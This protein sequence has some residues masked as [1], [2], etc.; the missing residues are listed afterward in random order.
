MNEEGIDVLLS[1]QS[2]PK[3]KIGFQIK[4]KTDYGRI[5]K[6]SPK[7]I[8]SFTSKVINQIVTSHKH[9]LFKS[10]VVFAADLTIKMVEDKVNA[11]IAAI[12]TNP[13]LDKYVEIITA[14]K[15][16]KIHEVYK[17]K[18]NPARLLFTEKGKSIDRILEGLQESH[19]TDS[20]EA[21]FSYTI[22]KRISITHNIPLNCR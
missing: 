13:E 12:S 21:T 19:T 22:K 8:E 3:I 4:S 9:K 14:E 1:F 18:E 2:M 5:S 7:D 6:E 16:S 15:I 11:A 10:Y 20:E 17:L